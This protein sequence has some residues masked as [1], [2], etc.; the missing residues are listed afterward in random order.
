MVGMVAFGFMLFSRFKRSLALPFALFFIYL[1]TLHGAWGILAQNDPNSGFTFQYLFSKLFAVRPDSTYV[2]TL[3]LYSL[4]VW[5]FCLSLLMMA[6]KHRVT[7]APVEVQV[8]G[9]MLVGGCFVYLAIAMSALYNSVS[10]SFSTNVSYYKI[11]QG[12]AGWSQGKPFLEAAMTISYLG[13]ALLASHRFGR[14]MRFRSSPGQF[15]KL[16]VFL[17]VFL[18]TF[19]ALIVGSKSMIFSSTVASVVFYQ[20]NLRY[21]NISSLLKL[22]GSLILAVIVLSIINVSRGLS[23]E[24]YNQLL[25]AENAKLAFQLIVYGNEAFGAHFSMYGALASEVKVAPET[26]VFFLIN[27]FSPID[28]GDTPSTYEYYADSVNAQSGQGYTIHYATGC[29]LNFGVPGIFLGAW[30]MAFIFVQ[31]FKAADGYFFSRE[32]ITQV[33]FVLGFALFVGNFPILLRGGLE[34]YRAL[35]ITVSIPLVVFI[36]ASNVRLRLL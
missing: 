7:H 26:A 21:R 9:W 23:F 14:M 22:L 3:L 19:L 10:L 5:V 15:L 6:P 2:I 29:Y 11:A 30:F 34:G 28:L 8:S 31:L 13:V 18:T 16:F 32:R 17:V 12:N 27:S 35:A 25:T 4:F 20:M 33:F 36:L 1:W 24:N